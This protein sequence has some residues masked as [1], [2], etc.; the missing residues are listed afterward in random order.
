[1]LR[2]AP[3]ALGELNVQLSVSTVFPAGCCTVRVEDV[4][5]RSVIVCV[6]FGFGQPGAPGIGFV[7]AVVV[8]R[9]FTFPF[10]ISL[11]GIAWLPVT[12]SAAGFWPGA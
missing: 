3:F 8:T 12:V 11:A 6:Q 4:N 1:M 7:G 10:L 5:A 9:K 2:M